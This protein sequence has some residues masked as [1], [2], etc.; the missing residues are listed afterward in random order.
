MA[1]KKKAEVKIKIPPGAFP[2]KKEM[3]ALTKAAKSVKRT[4]D[5]HFKKHKW[6]LDYS[7]LVEEVFYKAFGFHLENF[8]LRELFKSKKSKY[9]LCSPDDRSGLVVR[10]DK[11]KSRKVKN[12]K[13]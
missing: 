9:I 11:S 12:E 2:V 5:H 7:F 13:K 8:L 3:P 10:L 1:K 4:V 6:D